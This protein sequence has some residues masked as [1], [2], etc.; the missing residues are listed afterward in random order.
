M[1]VCLSQ[2]ALS[3]GSFGISLFLAF[4]FAFPFAILALASFL[5]A[6][7]VWHKLPLPLWGS[8]W[9]ILRVIFRR[10]GRALKT[11]ACLSTRRRRTFCPRALS[12]KTAVSWLDELNLVAVEGAVEQEDAGL[13]GRP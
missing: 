1:L 3:F 11:A 2:L 5:L 6:F 12:A 4:S 13:V 8:I 10:P 7:V 9:H